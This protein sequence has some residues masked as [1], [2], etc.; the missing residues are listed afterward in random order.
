MR[1]DTND[2]VRHDFIGMHDLNGK[3]AY[4]N[5]FRK[6]HAPLYNLAVVNTELIVSANYLQLCN[7]EA[8]SMVCFDLQNLTL[9]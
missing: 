2:T 6:T 4:D 9:F 5:F 3:Y 1:R 8:F 7:A